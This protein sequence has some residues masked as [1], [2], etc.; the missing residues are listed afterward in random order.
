MRKLL[1]RIVHD[2]L[3]PQKIFFPATRA[4]GLF[5]DLQQYAGRQVLTAGQ[6]KAYA[7]RFIA[8]HLEEIGHGQTY[9][10][11]SARYLKNPKD[12][13]LAQLRSTLFQGETLRGL[14]LNAWGGERSG[15]SCWSPGSSSW[16]W[17]RSCS[18]CPGELAGQRPR[19]RRAA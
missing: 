18:R 6:A 11:V 5:P 8:R 4:E 15:P 7:G 12:Q 3:A 1:G 13:Q 16:S 17:A 19:G 9:S 10:Q 2:R 14:L